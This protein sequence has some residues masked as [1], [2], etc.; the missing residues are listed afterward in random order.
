M[1]LRTAGD[2]HAPTGGEAGGRTMGAPRAR[3]GLVRE[4][5]GGPSRAALSSV[6]LEL[7]K[8]I[9]LVGPSPPPPTTR[10]NICRQRQPL[11][12]SRRQHLRIPSASARTLAPA[13]LL[14]LR[15][16]TR[17]RARSHHN[18]CPRRHSKEA[19]KGHTRAAGRAGMH[20]RSHTNN[21]ASNKSWLEP[22]GAQS[23]AVFA[24]RDDKS[25]QASPLALLLSP[26]ALSPPP[27]Q[28]FASQAGRPRHAAE[29]ATASN[30]LY[31]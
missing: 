18:N 26:F 20:T 13:Y 3:V 16:D 15:R 31:C 25:L 11:S 30:E 21:K 10:V 28:R 24:L 5:R 6:C 9:G 12:P 1:A 22:P 29:P 2:L 17:Q 14:S 19:I 23:S 8:W 7:W 27:R 4:F